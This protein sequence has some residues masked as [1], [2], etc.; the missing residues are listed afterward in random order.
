[1]YIEM[2]VLDKLILC[3]KHE[4]D[5]GKTTL[6]TLKFYEQII[7]FL[8]IILCSIYITTL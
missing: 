4:E 1:M 8:R 6:S 5:Y 2:Y 7:Y 3:I